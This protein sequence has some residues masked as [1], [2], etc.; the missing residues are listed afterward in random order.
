MAI[1]LG[2][3]KAVLLLVSMFYVDMASSQVVGSLEAAN[4]SLK[5]I[6]E[7]TQQL[8]VGYRKAFSQWDRTLRGF[9]RAHHLSIVSGVGKAYTKGHIFVDETK[10]PYDFKGQSTDLGVEYAFHLQ[11]YRKLGY[12]VG[13]RFGGID[14]LNM[15][16]SD[17]RS[18]YVMQLPGLRAGLILNLDSAWRASIGGQLAL[19]R[20][21]NFIPISELG[22]RLSL[23]LAGGMVD[24][25]LDW[26]FSLRQGIHFEY[27][28]YKWTYSYEET[29]GLER[30]GHSI[31]LGLISHLI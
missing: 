25:G 16:Q 4:K 5:Q 19:L 12:F 21:W 24:F 14:V 10:Y 13:T 29:I 2:R 20:Y 23:T 26:F 9:R 15:G 28:Y 11:L 3:L 1:E 27:Q 6:P 8:L 30:A 31:S 7:K 18:Q 17:G 22:N